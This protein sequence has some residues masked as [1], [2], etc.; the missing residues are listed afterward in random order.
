MTL[1]GVPIRPPAARP[2]RALLGLAALLLAACDPGPPGGGAVPMVEGDGFFDR[3]W[4]SDTR[5]LDGHPDLAGFPHE[6]DYA[7]VDDYL[8]AAD[9]VDGFGTNSPLYVRFEGAIDPALLP[10]PEESLDLRRSNVLLLDVTPGSPTRGEAVP[11]QFEWSPDAT[12]WKP[13]NLLAAAPVFGFPL[14]PGT[15]YAL[16]FRAPLVA[17]PPLGRPFV[18]SVSPLFAD[19]ADTVTGLDLDPERFSLAVVF[20]TQDPLAETARI[21]R[22]IHEEIA[23]PPFEPEL[24]LVAS[25]DEYELYTGHVLLPVWQWGERPYHDAGG[26]FRFD[27][28]GRPLVQQ[29]ERVEFALT[30]PHGPM[31]EGGWPVV[32]YAHGTGGDQFTF[33]QT[34]AVEE[35]GTVMAREGVAMIGVSQP[36][37]GDR[38]T[39]DTN[40]DLDTFNFYNPEAGRTNFRQGA[41]DQVYLANL[42]T[43]RQPSFTVD[44]KT[45]IRLDPRAVAFFGHSQGGLVGALATPFFDGQVRASGMSGAGGGL[46]MTILLRKDPVDIALILAALLEFDEDEALSTFHPV[47]GLVQTLV[48][49]TDPLNY[50][51]AWY[52]LP[53]HDGAVPTPILLTEGMEDAYTPPVTTEALAAAAR[54]PIA[55]PAASDPVALDLR[56]L[57]TLALPAADNAPTWDGGLVTAGLGQFPG[58]GHYAIYDDRT[59]RR[60][61]RNFLVAALEGGAP[62]LDED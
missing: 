62:V 43:V 3:P 32:L 48:E 20:T 12:A 2:A 24:D 11:L 47:V 38:S 58:Q 4:P 23:A 19:A 55:G 9:M 54:A 59:A 41:L 39:P 35:E 45:N 42:L 44:R 18:G 27:E 15:T 26:G 52:T 21:A 30:V 49:A 8:A 46:S 53:A 1:L 17:P 13:G 25:R 7:L 57:S 50:A 31:P 10:T 14:A 28:A 40:V 34:G 16:L 29:W 61:Y 37:H 6:G 60:F 22:A 33:C 36:L 5:L 56:G 51:P